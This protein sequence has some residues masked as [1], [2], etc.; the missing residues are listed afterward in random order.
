MVLV[1]MHGQWLSRRL[2]VGAHRVLRS[3]EDVYDEIEAQDNATLKHVK[4][5][6]SLSSRQLG[7]SC[8]RHNWLERVVERAR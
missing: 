5:S 4:R 3:T 1:G 6:G 2:G 7:K 8:T